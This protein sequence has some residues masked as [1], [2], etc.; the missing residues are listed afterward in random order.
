[1]NKQQLEIV[2]ALLNEMLDISGN[3]NIYNDH[4]NTSFSMESIMAAFPDL[5]V[6]LV[7]KLKERSNEE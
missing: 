6:W 7:E 5:P 3:V 2:T 4:D 1:M